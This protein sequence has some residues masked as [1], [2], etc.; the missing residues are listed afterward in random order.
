MN[1]ETYKPRLID[2]ESKLIQSPWIP[3]TERM[4][5]GQSEILAYDSVLED[6]W[7][8]TFFEKNNFEIV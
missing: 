8:V 6:V 5:E 2:A 1:T 7:L 4:P 3:V